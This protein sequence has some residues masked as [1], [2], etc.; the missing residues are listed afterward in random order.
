MVWSD[1]LAIEAQKWADKIAADGKMSHAPGKDR[2]G[3]GENIA[4]CKGEVLMWIQTD[5]I[6][7][8]LLGCKVKQ[9]NDRKYQ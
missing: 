7:N 2:A 3:Q 5:F 9:R 4:C 6:A 1:E 8:S